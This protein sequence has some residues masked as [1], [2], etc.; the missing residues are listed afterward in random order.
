MHKSF[1]AATTTAIVTLLLLTG[2]ADEDNQAAVDENSKPEL[3]GKVEHQGAEKT[4]PVAEKAEPAKPAKD[5][6]QDAPIMNQPVDFSTPESIAKTFKDIRE[7]AGGRAVRRIEGAMGYIMT[8]DLSVA[9]DEARM[10][11]KLNGKTPNEIIAM[12][13]ARR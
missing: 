12:G 7:E 6:G 9:R 1:L 3:A 10:Y 11:K 13:S 8:Y 5:A 2:C 4:R